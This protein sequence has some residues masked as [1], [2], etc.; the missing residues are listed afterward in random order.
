MSDVFISYARSTEGQARQ[1]GEALRA[2]GYGVWRDD[3]IPA[4]RA[5]ADVIR[6]RLK[7][8]KAV[9][10]V[11]SAEAANSEWVR[12]EAERARAGRKLVQLT[13]DGAELPMPFD[14]IQCAN[15]KGWSG[16]ADHPGWLKVLASI[17]TLTTGGTA[18]A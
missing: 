10:V 15:M 12:S 14:Q 6:E 13:L 1:I 11:W 18:P 16:G 5:Y 8:A 17:A 3:E 4:H 7:E 2:L 9:V